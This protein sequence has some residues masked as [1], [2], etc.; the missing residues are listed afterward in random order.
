MLSRLLVVILLGFLSPVHCWASAKTA[1]SIFPRLTG[2]G[3]LYVAQRGS[4]VVCAAKSKT[5]GGSTGVETNVE[6]IKSAG[7]IKEIE[8][9][10]MQ[11]EML[12]LA[13]FGRLRGVM[14]KVPI[15]S[16]ATM[17]SYPRSAVMDLASLTS[18]PCPELIDNGY[19][20]A[21]PWYQQLGL[22]LVAEQAKGCASKWANYIA[23][24]PDSIPTPAHWT[25]EQ[26]DKLCYPPIK[27]AVAEQ[28]LHFEALTDSARQ[29]LAA[30][31]SPN[32]LD[33]LEWA[34][35]VVL[36]RALDTVELRTQD[37]GLFGKIAASISR[38]TA[39]PSGTS[40][41]RAAKALVPMLDFVNHAT[42]AAPRFG[43]DAKSD[44]FSVTAERAYGKG[45]QVHSALCLL[46]DTLCLLADTLC[47]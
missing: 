45:E 17:L 18:C 9:A 20:K 7:F 47:L 34:M 19:W 23:L 3:G 31:A 26:L 29:H 40:G 15:R 43:Y 24:L 28:R 22:W 37:E 32:A 30:G 6:R 21:A 5:K 27:L 46:A 11:C 38:L 35:E 8:D 4:K 39:S 33:K 25:E 36:S 44:R 13:N 2:T 12:S 16:G 10:G 14:A 1:F 42:R 41:R